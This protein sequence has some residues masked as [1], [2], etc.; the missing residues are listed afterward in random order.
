VILG[1]L[2]LTEQHD[3]SFGLDVFGTTESAQS[4]RLVIEG[5]QFDVA[6]HCKIAN[7]EVTATV[8]KLKGILPAGVYESRLEVIVDGKIFTP[9]KEQIEL[10]PLIEFDVKT[11]KVSAVK[12]GVKVTTKAKIVSEDTRPAESKLEK[13]IQK[14]I[15]EGYE[16]SKVGDNYIMKKGDRYV[17]VI[18]ETK[19]LKA[20]QEYSTLTELIDGL[21]T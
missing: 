15:S 10:N 3:M 7:G 8:P 17:G 11:K 14:C 12:E 21:S 4:A 16:V 20:K 19:I 9:L 5:P 6:C 18:S 1:K 2:E 13:N